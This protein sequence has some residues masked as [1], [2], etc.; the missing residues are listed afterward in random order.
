MF[1]AQNVNIIFCKQV[2]QRVLQSEE[3]KT[4]SALTYFI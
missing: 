3:K 4:N 2:A 1:L